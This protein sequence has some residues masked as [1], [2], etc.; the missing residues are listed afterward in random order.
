MPR[1][2]V[3]VNS[4]EIPTHLSVIALNTKCL[5]QDIVDYIARHEVYDPTNPESP[6]RHKTIHLPGPAFGTSH[7]YLRWNS[8]EDAYEACPTEKLKVHHGEEPPILLPYIQFEIPGYPVP[9]G[10]YAS[11]I[12]LYVTQPKSIDKS[13]LSHVLRYYAK[14]RFKTH[15]FMV[16]FEFMVNPVVPDPKNDV[17]VR[18]QNIVHGFHAKRR[19]FPCFMENAP[20]N[21]IP[22]TPILPH[23]CNHNIKSCPIKQARRKLDRERRSLLKIQDT[24][25][26][27]DLFPETPQQHHTPTVSATA[28]SGALLALGDPSNDTPPIKKIKLPTSPIP[29]PT[30]ATILKDNPVPSSRPPLVHV[31]EEPKVIVFRNPPLSPDFAP[32]STP[33]PKPPSPPNNVLLTILG[34]A[35][36]PPIP[37]NEI[38]L[39]VP[40]LNFERHEIIRDPTLSQP[41]EML[42]TPPP[43]TPVM[44]PDPPSVQWSNEPPSSDLNLDDFD[45]NN[46]IHFNAQNYLT[47]TAHMNQDD[48][49]NLVSNDE[50]DAKYFDEHLSKYE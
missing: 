11:E 39:D 23:P 36:D 20:W 38:V 18:Q 5:N 41:S 30:L 49:C 1:G 7:A 15:T 37:T 46:F 13:V 50:F 33:S 24:P 25:L 6:P 31:D 14:T 44:Q 21:Q 2:R 19:Q 9:D 40:D 27:S 35:D 34:P 43:V 48:L 10:H 3:I 47:D 4:I 17:V 32:T 29:Q 16:V 28:T 45:I 8:A 12:T 26:D 42:N 22:D